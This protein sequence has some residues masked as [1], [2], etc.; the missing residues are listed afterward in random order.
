MAQSIAR[1]A[2]V[3]GGHSLRCERRGREIDSH[4]AIFRS[5]NAQ[6]ASPLINDQISRRLMRYRVPASHAGGGCTFRA[7]CLLRTEHP[8][9]CPAEVFFNHSCADWFAGRLGG[10]HGGIGKGG[11]IS[12]PGLIRSLQAARA[13]AQKEVCLVPSAWWAQPW[14]AEQFS[15]RQYA[16]CTTPRAFHYEFSKYTPWILGWLV[17]RG[18]NLVFST[19]GLQHTPD[20]DGAGRWLHA[21]T[22]GTGGS[23]LLTALS[24]CKDVT[25]YGTG[26]LRV[27]ASSVRAAEQKRFRDEESAILQTRRG[28]TRNV[29]AAGSHG[30]GYY[31]FLCCDRGC[32]TCGG[33]GCS[34][35]PNRT[36]RLWP[37]SQQSRLYARQRCCERGILSHRQRLYGPRG[38][39]CRHARDVGCYNEERHRW[40]ERAGRQTARAG[41]PRLIRPQ[42]VYAHF[43]DKRAALCTIDE[44][45]KDYANSLRICKGPRCQEMREEWW[46]DRIGSEL[47]LHLLHVFGI[48]TW[49]Q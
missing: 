46:Q 2:V 30:T 32:H 7:N 11:F 39:F 36:A 14:G 9:V 18:M 8:G 34:K 12:R 29:C 21:L 3:G 41:A 16:C 22:R 33:H 42:L 40:M 37:L 38:E 13:S 19:A 28:A 24:A 15:N 4:D 17:Q 43:Y 10:R 45:V 20:A 6:H 47:T 44:R 1:C 25:I 48:V 26:L 23:S 5:N 31:D 27:N 35:L 49:R